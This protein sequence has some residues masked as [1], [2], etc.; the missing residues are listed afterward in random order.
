MTWFDSSEPAPED[1]ACPKCGG[2]QVLR[3]KHPYPVL[4][5]ALFGISF[6]GFL[7]FFDKVSHIRGILTGWCATQIV[8]GIAL[9][10]GRSRAQLREMRCIRCRAGLA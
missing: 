9:I 4:L 7:I 8:L 3:Q 10:R 1:E 5:Q 6:V 2:P